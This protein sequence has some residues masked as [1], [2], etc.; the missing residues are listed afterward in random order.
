MVCGPYAIGRSDADTRLRSDVSGARWPSK[1]QDSSPWARTW[2]SDP[3]AEQHHAGQL[4]QQGSP[5]RDPG[6]LKPR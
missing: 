4:R 6:G 2:K 1:G 5:A 3:S